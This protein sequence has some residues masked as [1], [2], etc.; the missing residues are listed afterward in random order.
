MIEHYQNLFLFPIQ[1]SFGRRSILRPV[2]IATVLLWFAITAH[3]GGHAKRL[4]ERKEIIGSA[5]IT[6][7]DRVYF[8][9]VNCFAFSSYV[10]V[11]IQLN[12]RI[13]S[14]FC[15]SEY[16]ATRGRCACVRV[17]V[18]VLPTEKL[19]VGKTHAI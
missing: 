3:F 4:S 5:E 16:N 8:R 14:G 15:T 18:C 19:S 13:P 7:C 10:G 2:L 17:R 6:H 11:I 12:T 1:T 9:T